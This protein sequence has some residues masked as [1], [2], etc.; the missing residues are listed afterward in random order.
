MKELNILSPG[1]RLKEI[2]K[3]LR[4]RQD[5]LAGDRFSKNYISMFENGKRTINAI[6]AA[7]LASQINE[8]A[9]MKGK[10]IN[11]NASYLLKSERDMAKE[12]CEKWID[13]LELK[14]NMSFRDYNINLYKIIHI[15][16]KYG[17]A[18]YKAKA[19]HLKGLLYLESGRY[20]CAMTQFLGALVYYGKEND[21]MNISEIYKRLGTIAYKNKQ[22]Q[23][24]F[25]YFTL[26]HTIVKMNN[27]NDI[28]KI[29]EFNY[30]IAL[31][32]YDMGQY[33]M[34]EKIL[35]LCEVRNNKYLDL[36]EKIN[37]ALLA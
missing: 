28:K 16:S 5:E 15:S 4:L 7:Y 34:A 19:L 13:E 31:C 26:G 9:K 27:K 21:F 17:L 6:N 3:L 18:S 37:K 14:P 29:D 25:V 22:L 1:Q 24:A 12:N 20:E 32:Y 33:P 2:R 11:L 10:D 23:Q 35:E 30:L 36:N 8:F